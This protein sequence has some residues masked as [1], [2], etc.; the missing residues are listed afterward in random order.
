MEARSN[1]YAV[2]EIRALDPIRAFQFVG[3]DVTSMTIEQERSRWHLIIVPNVNVTS[4]NA[5]LALYHDVGNRFTHRGEARSRFD[6]IRL[7]PRRCM[8]AGSTCSFA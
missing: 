1:C 8:A 2:R 5:D 7:G 6:L 4:L 3:S